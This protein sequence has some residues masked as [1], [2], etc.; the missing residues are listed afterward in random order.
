MV[1]QTV[2]LVRHADEDRLVWDIRMDE[3]QFQLDDIVVTATLRPVRVPDRPTPRSIE[4]NLTPDMIA[5]LPIDPD[6]DPQMIRPW[7]DQ[8]RESVRKAPKRSWN[9]HGG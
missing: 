6:A 3:P 8:A 9:S 5:A 4:R 7:L 2:T 1:P